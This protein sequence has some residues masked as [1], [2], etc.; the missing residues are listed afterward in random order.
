MTAQSIPVQQCQACG[1]YSTRI[2]KDHH[3]CQR[4]GCRQAARTPKAGLEEQLQISRPTTA[5]PRADVQPMLSRLAD[6]D[7]RR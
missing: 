1:A 3:I 2:F 4:C 6:G 7:Y 5:V